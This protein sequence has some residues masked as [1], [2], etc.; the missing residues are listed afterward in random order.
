MCRETLK[1]MQACFQGRRL[2]SHRPPKVSND[3]EFGATQLEARHAEQART[4]ERGIGAGVHP[5]RLESGLQAELLDEPLGRLIEV[6]HV[7]R[8]LARHRRGELA[9]QRGGDLGRRR[10]ERADARA[11]DGRAD[12]AEARDLA[13]LQRHQRGALGCGDPGR[14]EAVARFGEEAAVVGGELVERHARAHRR[15]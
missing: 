11:G 13:V 4:I 15:S 5:R 14:Q 8:D 3:S 7:D 2:I 9:D 12:H 10:V 6:R 1:C